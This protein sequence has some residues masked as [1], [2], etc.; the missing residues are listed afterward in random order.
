MRARPELRRLA[1]QPHPAARPL[2]AGLAAAL[3]GRES[4][5]ERAAIARIE[6]LRARLLTCDRALT[7][8]EY[9]QG[10]GGTSSPAGDSSSGRT[11]TRTVGEICRTTS[12]P[13]R[14]GFLLFQLVRHLRPERCL[15]L[16]TSLGISAAYQAVA[17]SLNGR[18]RMTTLEGAEP[19]ATLAASNLNELGLPHAR[20]VVGRF[21]D[22]IDGAVRE[23]GLIEFA[24]VDG[25]HDRE[26]TIA[27]FNRIAR[28]A[29]THAVV[30]FDDIA[31][32]QGMEEAWRTIRRDRRVALIIDLGDVGICALGEGQSR[33]F[34]LALQFA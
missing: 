30:A 20:V 6:A 1:A 28:G 10:A 22:T 18:G 19:V 7:V 31:W 34:E 8:V 9:G 29:D 33:P 3:S 12:K 32:S 5:G 11:V 27:Y 16:G 2:A 25:H 23:L 14:W 17:L 21:Q 26:A 13:P 4:V 24:F 15:E